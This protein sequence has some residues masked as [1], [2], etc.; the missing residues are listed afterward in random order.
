M[1][2][3]RRKKIDFSVAPSDSEA[4]GVEFN[5]RVSNL[6]SPPK[7]RKTNKSK[8]DDDDTAFNHRS[9]SPKGKG[10]A[11]SEQPQLIIRR[12]GRGGKLRDLMNMPVDIFAEVCFY[13]EP[14]DLRRLALTSKRMWDVLMTKESRSLWK[15]ALDA[16]P[17]LPS[18]PRDLNEPQYVFLLFSSEC[19]TTGCGSRGTRV[20]W[21]HRVRYCTLCHESEMTTSWILGTDVELRKQFDVDALYDVK[22][23]FVSD[24]VMRRSRRQA[25]QTKDENNIRISTLK[26]ATAEY[27]ALST[28]FDQVAW[29]DKLK[30]DRAYR[31]S[32]GRAMLEWKS[33]QIADRSKD[34]EKVKQARFERYHSLTNSPYKE[35][36]ASPLIPVALPS[37]KIKLLELG[38]E[39]QD[40]PMQI[41]DF[42][43][44]VLKDQK[45]TTKIWQIILPK[46]E[47]LLQTERAERLEREKN[48][49][50]VAR[51][52]VIQEFYQQLGQGTLKLPFKIYHY[53]SKW[54]FPNLEDLME[55]PSVKTIVEEDTETVTE[56]R[57]IEVAP[58]VRM[59][60]LKWWRDSLAKFVTAMETGCSEVVGS[61]G[62]E[63]EQTEGETQED[64]EGAISLAIEALQ[65]R[66]AYATSGFI[67]GSAYYARVTW[68]FQQVQRQIS[69]WSCNMDLIRQDLK[70]FDSQS[71]RL[72][73]RMLM[74]LGFEEPETVRWTEVVKDT[75][76][77]LCRRCDERIA[78]YMDFGELIMHYLDANK[79]YNEVTDAIRTDPDK[80]YPSRTGNGELLR[81]INDHDW[82]SDDA[83]I[84][85]KDDEASRQAVLN[86]Q[87]AA[88]QEWFTSLIS[89]TGV[90]DLPRREIRRGCTL[91]PAEYAPNP[92]TTMNIELHIRARHGKEPDLHTDTTRKKLSPDFPCPL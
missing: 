77:Y 3:T 25:G 31:I 56:D 67:S 7:R 57:W 84:L 59:F 22:H 66:L 42:R 54:F 36:I 26:Q 49:R 79:W 19:N 44:F 86:S 65:D 61:D 40:F 41:K 58:D 1:V 50:R 34:I 72:V 39:E 24:P 29:L 60:V 8:Q 21:Y 75:K 14:F 78:K 2:I 32:T 90:A 74:D 63:T 51:E 88:V 28:R 80:C 47:R 20:D 9:S 23:Y 73:I 16:V 46:L 89:D 82:L 85:R 10:K 37:I 81:I 6:K 87:V 52:A 43:D 15:R 12:A 71:K 35:I 5:G 92:S 70:P 53:Q 38:W 13:L 64:T 27:A 18:C 62:V 48:Q 30:E 69:S 83:A 4:E 45:L 11:V 55:L 68:L 17:D 76:E 91:C 33:K